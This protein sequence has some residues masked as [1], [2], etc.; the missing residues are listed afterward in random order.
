MRKTKVESMWQV[1]AHTLYAGQAATYG[2]LVSH[3]FSWDRQYLSV[4]LNQGQC[5]QPSSKRSGCRNEQ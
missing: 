1:V 5:Y 2:G 3:I 4:A